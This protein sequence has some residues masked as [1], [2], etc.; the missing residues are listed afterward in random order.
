MRIARGVLSAV[1]LVV[2]CVLAPLGALSTWAKYEI[3]DTDRYVATLAPLADDPDVRTSVADAVTDEVV[4]AVDVGPLQG[5][6][7]DFVHEAV[8][9]FAGTKAY[10]GA[11][12]TAT[13]ATHNAFIDALDDGAADK[14]TLDLAPVVER[15]RQQLIEDDVP[16]AGRIPVPHVEVTL[17][18]SVDLG[19]FRKGFHMLEAAGIWFPVAAVVCAL[20]GVALAAR[21]AR[22]MILTGI[23]VVLAAGVLALG[24]ALARRATLDDLPASVSTDAVAAVY[25]ALTA[26]LRTSVWVLVIVG[27]V[28]VVAGGVTARLRR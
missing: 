1:A 18:D 7:R 2:A 9:S 24:L 3:A 26:T 21:R 5:T 13:R 8:I 12:D 16:F 27:V 19:G 22:A 25:D 15:V 11:W 14:V 17:L 10:Q 28:A 4:K 20:V 6:V 23:G